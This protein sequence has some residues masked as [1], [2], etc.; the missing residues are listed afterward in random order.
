MNGLLA[1]MLCTTRSMFHVKH[2]HKF[3]H[4][5][6]ETPSPCGQNEE[7]AIGIPRRSP[8]FAG[9]LAFTALA[10][11]VLVGCGGVAEAAGWS[12][13]TRLSDGNVLI[14]AKPGQ[15]RAVDPDS[16]TERWR[17]PDQA[18]SSGGGFGAMFRSTK[19]D[20]IAGTFYAAPILDK[21]QIYLVSYEGG[22]V[23]LNRGDGGVSKAWITQLQEKVVATPALSGGR[24]YIAT[25]TGEIVVVSA[26]DGAI[27]TRYR[28]GSGRIWGGMTVSGENLIT[29]NLDERAVYALRLSDGQQ[30]WRAPDAA[31][32]GDVVNAGPNLLVG[33]I[34]GSLR[35]FDATGGG[36]RWRFDAD[37]WVTTAPV[38]TGDTIYIGSMGGSVYALSLDGQ[39]RQ[40]FT[41]DAEKA[42]FR[43]APVM[44]NGTL[45]IAS[46]RGVV[47]GLDPAT[48]QQKWRAA[49]NDVRI[50]ASPLVIDGQVFLITTKHA[51]IRVDASSGAHRLISA[52]SE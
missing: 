22:V 34:D 15:V 40:Q 33:G 1:Q 7:P 3:I 10:A 47:V 39:Q 18:P 42:E 30:A 49:I 48:L 19:P 2:I 51:L 31:S 25:E 4:N 17:Y 29:P 36:V 28:A 50:D 52:P 37:G 21:D 27:T 45:V 6:G 32:V 16:G 13:P 12:A 23:R 24:L 8:R 20:V 35:A 43:S 14:Q 41:L 38:V 9:L 44:A 46:R 11:L 26:A 5:R